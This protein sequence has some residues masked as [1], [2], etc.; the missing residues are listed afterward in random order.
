MLVNNINKTFKLKRGCIIGCIEPIL[1]EATV[2]INNINKIKETT[3]EINLKEV[4][5][6]EEFRPHM[7]KIV[8][9]KNIFAEKDT[10][11]GRTETIKMKINTRDNP[12]IKLKPYRMPLQQRQ[13]VEKNAKIIRQS[14]SPWSA[15]IV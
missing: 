8:L 1:E 9:R 12:P 3:N 7:E 6:P 14:H 10:Q 2:S 5:V 13:I 15:P 4:N 11:F